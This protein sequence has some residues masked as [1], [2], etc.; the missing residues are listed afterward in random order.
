MSF[1][2]V[3]IVPY[4][5]SLFHIYTPVIPYDEHHKNLFSLSKVFM[6]FQAESLKKLDLVFHRLSQHAGSIHRGWQD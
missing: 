5:G 4:V 2:G 3:T 1:K 6:F